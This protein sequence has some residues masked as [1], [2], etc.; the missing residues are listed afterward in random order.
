MLSRR[1]SPSRSGRSV[2]GAGGVATVFLAVAL[3]VACAPR[4]PAPPPGPVGPRC[5]FGPRAVVASTSGAAALAR[6]I[7]VVLPEGFD[8]GQAPIPAGPAERVLY[9]QLYQTLVGVG[10]A[11]EA[12]PLLARS[13]R[14]DE[15]G[16]RWT[17]TLRTGLRDWEGGPVT[18]ARVVEGWLATQESAR[19][20]VRPARA[21]GPFARL[22]V[23]DPLTFL[24]ETRE[25]VA[26]TFFARPELAV[27]TGAGVEGWPIGTGPFRPADLSRRPA[28]GS[29]VHLTGPTA[30]E[31]RP[32]SPDPRDDLD[33]G[34]DLLVSDDPA[35]I[36]YALATSA[37]EAFPLGW[38]RAYLLLTREPAVPASHPGEPS[39]QAPAVPLVLRGPERALAA[40]ARDAVRGEARAADWLPAA[41]PIPPAAASGEPVRTLAPRVVYPAG[42]RVA[43][44]LAERLVAQARR[45]GSAD[46]AWLSGSLPALMG[47]ERPSA[48]GLPEPAFLESLRQGRDAAY[49][50]S[51]EVDHEAD[52]CGELERAAVL[53]PWLREAAARAGGGLEPATA[54]PLVETRATLLVRRGLEGLALDGQG[55]LHLEGLRRI[56]GGR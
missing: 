45:P 54:V 56:G 41:C 37:F 49:L 36:E 2:V 51:V 34:A 31:L 7:G 42:D 50:V 5:A 28:P 35:V 43:R 23:L 29:P 25:P 16:R 55:V 44:S 17:F 14:V 20:P 6:P 38:E 8:P 48:V 27:R 10:C 22:G 18:A 46:A 24:V 53:A 26:A 3:A 1:R 15:E 33:L 47:R 19:E 30:L 52:G 9:A 4:G 40:L 11:G 32:P 21:P 12:E 13:W 39:G